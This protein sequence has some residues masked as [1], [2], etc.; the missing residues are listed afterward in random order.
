MRKG[1]IRLGVVASVAW[2]IA[3]G[4]YVRQV[5]LERAGNFMG[6]S[7]QACSQQQYAQTGSIDGCADEAAATY[8]DMLKGSWG[9][10]AIAAFVPIPVGWLL[11]LLVLNVFA[12]VRAGFRPE[13]GK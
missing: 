2:A 4:Y 7:Y 1:W 13:A 5:D 9:N 12:W 10:T 6:E 8:S 11:A 3:A